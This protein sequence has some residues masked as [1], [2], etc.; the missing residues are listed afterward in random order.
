MFFFLF[1][2]VILSTALF[3]VYLVVKTSQVIDVLSLFLKVERVEHLQIVNCDF[4]TF[5]KILKQR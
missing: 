2:N 4:M 3:A 5:H 1:G